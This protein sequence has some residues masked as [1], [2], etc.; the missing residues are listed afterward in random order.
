MKGNET[1]IIPGP[2][3]CATWDSARDSAS[4][5]GCYGMLRVSNGAF[6]GEN[7]LHMEINGAICSGFDMIRP[8]PGVEANPLMTTTVKQPDA[9]R[10]PDQLVK[11]PFSAQIHQ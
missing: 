5:T 10:S 2:A 4:A 3:P 1:V 11:A 9:G 6:N 7:N 8:A